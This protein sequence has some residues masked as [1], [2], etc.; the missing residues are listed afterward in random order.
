MFRRAGIVT[1]I[2]ILSCTGHGAVAQT[3]SVLVGEAIRLTNE[4]S[5]WAEVTSAIVAPG[6]NPACPDGRLL[7]TRSYQTISVKLDGT[8]VKS[9]ALPKA[10]S[11]PSVHG[12]PVQPHVIHDQHMVSLKDGG[13]LQSIEAITWND[14]L[15]P[16]PP[17]WNWTSDYPLKGKLAAGGR[18]TI[19]I[20]RTT[21]CGATWALISEID[22][23]RLP[24]KDIRGL[25]SNDAPVATRGPYL[26]AHAARSPTVGLCGTPRR[27]AGVAATGN[28][29][30]VP[31]H[32]EGGGW[33][34]HYLYSDTA[35]GNLILTTPCYF[36]TDEIG[37]HSVQRLWIVSRDGGMN[38]HVARHTD[39]FNTF[40]M[41]VTSDGQ[42]GAVT[43]YTTG[44]QGGPS[45][46]LQR[47]VGLSAPHQW[48]DYRD[49]PILAPITNDTR[50]AEQK[51]AAQFESHVWAA[52]ILTP[53]RGAT[54]MVK[55]GVWRW[56]NGS[57]LVYDIY[58]VDV[59]GTNVR[60]IDTLTGLEGDS[61][62]ME[63]MFVDGPPDRPLDLLYWIER[64]PKTVGPNDFRIR[65]QVYAG[66]IPMLATPGTL[67]LA[68]G[69][70]YVWGYRKVFAGEYMGGGSYIGE[71]GTLHFVAPWVQN[72]ALFVN[73][74]AVPATAQ[75]MAQS[76]RKVPIDVMATRPPWRATR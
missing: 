67:T 65:F 69:Q 49:G 30:A 28:M 36:G 70:P 59:N 76:G 5:G 57:R 12:E 3:A 22:A 38:W 24:V 42:G 9:W 15:Q 11:N 74:V 1:L 31:K 34:G 25:P 27:F 33:D 4:G 23:G 64:I 13:V 63:A 66:E 60:R 14:N 45:F 48:L 16:R 72:G 29:P 53:A 52:P 7:V 58:R 40:R 6:R 44:G 32:A 73:T 26:R 56:I 68:N 62:V 17:W 47:L 41:P 55:A 18:A 39:Q 46:R 8:D 75:R 35:T 10:S 54:S 51:A 19:Y 20:Y 71:D 37:K 2:S 43:L 61:D 50:T 21:D